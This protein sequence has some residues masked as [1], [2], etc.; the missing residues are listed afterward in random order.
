MNTIVLNAGKAIMQN[1]M[2]VNLSALAELGQ[3]LQECLTFPPSTSWAQICVT[4]YFEPPVRSIA[5]HALKHTG[6]P[7]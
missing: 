3:A 2:S 1:R 5:A 4:G 7:C 6:Q